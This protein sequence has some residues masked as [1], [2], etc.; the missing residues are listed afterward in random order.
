MRFG[1]IE[2]CAALAVAAVVLVAGGPLRA[3]DTSGVRTVAEELGSRTKAPDAPA[4]GSKGLSDSAVR[5]MSTFAL[6]ILPD[7]V[8]DGKGGKTK[9]DKS[10][11]NLYLIPIDDARQVIRVATRSAYAEV[12]NLLDLEKTN[13]NTLMKNELARNTWSQQQMMFISALHTFATSYFAGNVKITEQADDTKPK[14]GAA[15][16]AVNGAATTITSKKLECAPGQREKVAQAITAYVQQSTP[17]APA[18]QAAPA[19]APAAP[20]SGG[21]N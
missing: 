6:S 11:P 12:C 15:A 20:V 3:D 17:Q 2:R 18:A 14:Q 7:E 21:P 4:S 13:F 5:V 16:N 10:N 19:A 8:P 9:L 1:L